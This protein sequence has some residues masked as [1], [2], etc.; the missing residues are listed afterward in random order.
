MIA[1]ISTSSIHSVY[2][3]TLP[4][5][6]LHYISL[7]YTTL[8]YITL[9]YLTLHYTTLPCITSPYITLPYTSLPCTTLHYIKLHYITLHYIT[10]T[11]H[12]ENSGACMSPTLRNC[13]GTRA[14]CGIGDREGDRSRSGSLGASCMEAT[15]AIHPWSSLPPSV[16]YPPWGLVGFI[17][18]FEHGQHLPKLPGVLFI[19]RCPA[20]GRHKLLDG[21]W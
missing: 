6:T 19:F 18:G 15:R 7:P 14:W 17:R 9:R 12:H 20:Q 8:H 1:M 3:V 5:I 10:I 16:G 13:G 21:P 4:Y 2:V 11:L